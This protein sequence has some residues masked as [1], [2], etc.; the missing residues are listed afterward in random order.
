MDFFR[1]KD[2]GTTLKT[3]AIAG[4]TTFMTMS[5]IIF[6]QPAILS[7]AGMNFGAV[8]MATIISSII[9]ILI[10]GLYANYPIALAPAMGENFLFAFTIVLGMGVA[11]DKALGIVFISG[12]LFIIL[13][14]LKVRESV[15]NSVPEGL[16][17]AIAAGIG[18]FITFIGLQWSGLIVK[19]PA[20]GVA[21]GDVSTNFVILFLIGLIVMF[22][23][24]AKKIK[25]AILLGIIATAI[26]GIPMGIVRFQGF[27]SAPPSI[28]PTFFKLDILGALRWE[29]ITPIV[30]LFLL[31]F[32]DTVGTLIGVGSH[33]GFLRDGKLPRAGKALMADAIGTVAGSL[34]GTS[35]VSSYIESAAGVS[36]G[37]K[38]GLSNM[39]TALCFLLAIFFYPVVK[40]IGGGFSVGEVVYYPVIAPA[41]VIVG[42]LMIKSIAGIKWDDPTESIPVFL[43][44]IGIPL[45]YSISDGMAFGFISY[46][47]M[48]LFAGRIKE[49]SPVMWVLFAIFVFRF[50]ALP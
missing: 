50:I 8:M 31:D 47:L 44:L 48:K 10:M 35:T 28:S 29:Y 42:C 15:I 22:F 46:P 2:N 19:S 7:H 27:V 14:L 5:Y 32:F 39:F 34:L 16:K 38:T 17:K 11:W 3:E 40:A 33:A 13:T 12:I 30:V 49:V 4:I 24:I 43:T 41:L 9:A 1:L 18:I 37:G 20:T 36:E 45:T 23:L 26:I 6:V 25:G 21:L